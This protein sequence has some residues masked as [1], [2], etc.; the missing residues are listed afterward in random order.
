MFFV[1]ENI[2]FLYEN[3]FT[4]EYDGKLISSFKLLLRFRAEPFLEMDF[5]FLLAHNPR[6]ELI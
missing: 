2:S 6:M 1:H 4:P 3:I 5:V